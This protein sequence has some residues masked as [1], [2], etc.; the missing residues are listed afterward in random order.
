VATN[1]SNA[2]ATRIVRGGDAAVF[3]ARAR[4]AIG[5]DRAIAASWLAAQEHEI[6]EGHCHLLPPALLP[7]MARAQLTRDAVIASALREHAANG[8]VL[9]AGNGHVRRDIGVPRWLPR[10]AQ[11]RVLAVAF[12]EPDADPSL[13]AAVDAV[14]RVPAATRDDPCAGVAP[15][16]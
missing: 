13:V 15:P 8:I 3:D 16:R 9:M 12:V 6:E 10:E 2:D 11:P 1:P 4:T 7:A 14:V 5:L